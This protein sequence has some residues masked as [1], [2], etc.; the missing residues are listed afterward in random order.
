M[1]GLKP[2]AIPA[3]LDLAIE[4]W[5]DGALLGIC[6]LYRS[7]RGFDVGYMLLKKHWGC[8]YATEAVGLMLHAVFQ[9]HTDLSVSSSTTVWADVDP[10]NSASLNV[11]CKLGFV[12][13]G[14]EEDAAKV[15]E[16]LRDSVYMAVTMRAFRASAWFLLYSETCNLDGARL[17]LA[18]DER[19]Q[20]AQ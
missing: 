20:D 12:Q 13:E 1:R 16:E 11:L 17:H 19:P 5:S 4:R 18:C 2:P 9:Q 14:F 6:S 10:R 15:G 7:I 3:T 8:G